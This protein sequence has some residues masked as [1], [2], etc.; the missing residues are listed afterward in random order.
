MLKFDWDE[1]K[2]RANQRKHGVTLEEAQT[3]FFDEDAIEFD[4]PRESIKET[5]FLI[6]GRSI[7]LCILIISYCFRESIIRIISARKAT[8][9]ERTYYISR[10]KSS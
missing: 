1:G 5:R 7:R 6:I 10:G 9:K 4:D 2:N 3:V 8:S